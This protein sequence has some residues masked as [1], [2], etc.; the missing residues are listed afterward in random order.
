MLQKRPQTR[1]HRRSNVPLTQ[2]PV[3]LKHDRPSD[4]THEVGHH[5]L[6]RH[7]VERVEQP[8]VRELFKPTPGSDVVK[9]LVA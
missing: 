3:I 1:L 2:A 8:L 6:T 4:G 9:L 7:D 5:P